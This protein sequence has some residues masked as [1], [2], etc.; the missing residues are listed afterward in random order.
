MQDGLIALKLL[1]K[2][3]VNEWEMCLWHLQPA[4]VRGLL[5]LLISTVILHMFKRP[6]TTL[7]VFWQY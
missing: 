1:R 7:E 4:A 5:Y 6:E 2:C 3:V